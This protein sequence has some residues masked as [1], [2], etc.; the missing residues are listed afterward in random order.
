MR[1]IFIKTLRNFEKIVQNF[2][3]FWKFWENFKQIMKNFVNIFLFFYSFQIKFQSVS[4]KPAKIWGG[5][6]M[7]WN[8]FLQNLGGRPP[9][10]PP[11]ADPMVCSDSNGKCNRESRPNEI[12][13]SNSFTRLR[14]SL[15]SL[16][17]HYRFKL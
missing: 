13:Q 17:T 2:R 10:A 12:S 6:G 9:P 7:Y 15:V 1:T 8:K 4:T 14:L 11:A 16:S 5:G 3:D